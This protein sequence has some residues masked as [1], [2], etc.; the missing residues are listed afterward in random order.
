MELKLLLLYVPRCAIVAAN[1]QVW[2]LISGADF[3]VKSVLFSLL[4]FSIGSWSIILA[5]I[6]SFRKIKQESG[7]FLHTFRT[8]RKIDDLAKSASDFQNCPE[9]RVFTAGYYEL[10]RMSMD[11]GG[12]KES[13]G[14]NAADPFFLSNRLE[15]I[16]R[17]LRQTVANEVADLEKMMMFLATTG[18]TAPFIGLFGTVWGIMNSFRGLI[19]ASGSQSISAVAPGISEALIATAVG[20]VAAIPAVVAYNFFMARIRRIQVNLENFTAEYLNHLERHV[21]SR[22]TGHKESV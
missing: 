3:I 16:E 15:G 4:L 22:L 12:K 17:I 20:L 19:H 8:S 1:G 10:K 7:M 14:V 2:E 11:G 13:V 18:S 9:A 5:K 6:L 21:V